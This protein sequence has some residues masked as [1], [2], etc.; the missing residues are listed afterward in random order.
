MEKEELTVM[1]SKLLHKV[2]SLEQKIAEL[3]SQL[4]QEREEKLAA[5]EKHCEFD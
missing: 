2:V 5:Q 1:E 3:K 4:I